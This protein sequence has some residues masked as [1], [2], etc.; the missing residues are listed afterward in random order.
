MFPPV[1]LLFPGLGELAKILPHVGQ[2]PLTLGRMDSF[3]IHDQV[4]GH[5]G[6]IESFIRIRDEEIR[7]VVD[8]A[9]VEGCRWP[10]P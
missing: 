3:K 6:N 8:K 2:E 1:K 4:V 5:R 7:S 10:A 9:L